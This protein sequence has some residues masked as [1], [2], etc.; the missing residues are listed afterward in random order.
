MAS[1]SSYSSSIITTSS[2]S[3]VTLSSS[4][5][6]ST[7]VQTNN[8]SSSESLASILKEIENSFA[9]FA[10]ADKDALKK[11]L[12]KAY[13]LLCSSSSEK[14]GL[15]EKLLYSA[16]RIFHIFGRCLYGGDMSASRQMFQLSLGIQAIA[17]GAFK[18]EEFLKL[19]IKGKNLEDLSKQLSE[20]D[21]LNTVDKW[22][23][24][25]KKKELL[26]L[27]INSSSDEKFS[28]ATTLRWL[29]HS[30]QNID[31]LKGKDNLDFFV[32]VY[33]TAKRLLGS[34]N[35]DRANWESAEIEYNTGRFIHYLGK[36]NDIL[37]AIKTLDKV[38][39]AIEKTKKGEDKALALK[40][41][42]LEAQ[43]Y[44]I[45]AIELSKIPKGTKQEEI[46]LLKAQYGAASK[47]S[48]IADETKGF[49]PFLKTMFKHNKAAHALECLQLGEEVAKVDEIE[50]WVKEALTEAAETGHD[51]YYHA[52]YYIGAA[53]L[54][55]YKK[56]SDQA[57]KHLDTAEMINKKYPDNSA[58]FQA[59]V[60]ALRK[61]IS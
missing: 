41:T 12:N 9:N 10:S 16:S 18:S 36:P 39:D 30:C 27:G 20:T 26:E 1:S 7:T 37:G 54:A 47:A 23:M 55:L 19:A 49:D 59:K 35:T 34:L 58:G 28:L 5:S 53:R 6:D 52:T 42:V 43:V 61:E 57:K 4:S 48:K 21:K 40:A 25:A 11:Q 2:A 13:S 44:N 56:D 22:L 14:E 29:G 3:S 51:H 46:M 50:G 24:E 32:T 45:K 8:T 33:G 17:L 60:E 15:S 38:S 31:K